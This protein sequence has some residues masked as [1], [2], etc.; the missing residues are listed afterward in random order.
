M[1]TSSYKVIFS[2]KK[3]SEREKIVLTFRSVLPE[4]EYN[5]QPSFIAELKQKSEEV[6]NVLFFKNIE[7]V[8]K[9]G[10][11]MSIKLY[12]SY[13]IVLYSKKKG[14]IKEGLLFGNTKKGKINF[15]GLWPFNSDKDNFSK[16]KFASITYQLNSNF[17]DYD[18]ICLIV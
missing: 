16:E 14:G 12:E 8:I 3:E 18:F 15:I 5:I 9:L 2:G 7:E 6:D 11:N 10:N 4:R 1:N 17:N 13:S